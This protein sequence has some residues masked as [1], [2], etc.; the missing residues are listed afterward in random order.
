MSAAVARL[1]VFF[2]SAAVLVLEILAG[3][4]L[5]PY[6]GVT[7]ET[8]TGIIGTVLAGIS[9]GSW[10]GGRAADRYPPHK[11]LGPLLIS[12]GIL[13]MLSPTI[14]TWAGSSLTGSDPITIVTLTALGFFA[15]AV[16]LSAVSPVVVKIQLRTLD[17]TGSIVGQLSAIGT[18]GAIFGTF[19]TGFFLLA[20][21]PSRPIVLVVGTL[22]VAVGL[23]LSFRASTLVPATAAAL[24]VVAVV[25]GGMTFAVAGPCEVETAY[26]CARVTV[27]ADRPTG[28]VLWLDTLR[29]SYVDLE[30]PTHLEFRY[31]K[32]LSDSVLTVAP[33]GALDAIYVGGGGFT[34]PRW[35]SVVRPGSTNTVLELDAELVEIAV[36]DLGLVREE[37]DRIEVGD[38][39]LTLAATPLDTFELAVG[40]AFGGESVPWHL[41]TQE[42]LEELATHMT[43][44][45]MYVMNLIDYPPS[46]FARAEAATLQRVFDNVAVIAP[47]DYFYGTRG[48]NYVLVATNAPIDETALTA[49]IATRGAGELVLVEDALEEWLD[50]AK[51]LTDDFAPVDQLIRR[52]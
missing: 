47:A 1:L 11:L 44:D 33:E 5:A 25:A 8:F 46:G 24:V 39:R 9:I 42:F 51:P 3:R 6:V 20:A 19:V 41:T 36:R 16:V 32:L 26:F 13:T 12:G 21:W 29:H 49:A 52:S 15:P 18:A 38:A 14:I 31:A 40:D 17:E 10:L 30:D 4:L 7:L 28:R 50:G 27:D 22:L 43:D 48:G 23:L 2:T 37:I 45:G 35:L 34:L